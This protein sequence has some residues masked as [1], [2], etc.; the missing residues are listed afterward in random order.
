MTAIKNS[1]PVKVRMTNRAGNIVG[2]QILPIGLEYSEKDDKIRIIA[3]GCKFR[4]INDSFN[5]RYGSSKREKIKNLTL[6]ITD[7]RHSLERALM[8]FAHFEKRAE[9]L[10]G[11]KYI[12]H[13]NYY[14]NDETEL[15]IRV[16]SFGPY[17]K[18]LEPQ[19]FVNLIKDRLLL[20]KSCDCKPR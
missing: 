14:E 18:V 6:E 11:D 2:L 8:H 13:L 9:R 20:Q 16:L 5:N 10:E 3:T 12:L 4:Q 17:I 15:V 19:S 7:E 1:R